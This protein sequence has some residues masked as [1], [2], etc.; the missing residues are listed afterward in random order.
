M[1]DCGH[2]DHLIERRD[3]I[4]SSARVPAQA[5]ARIKGKPFHRPAAK[6]H[7]IKVDV[8]SGEK[9]ITRLDVPKA[10]P[11]PVTRPP[12]PR[13][14]RRKSNYSTRIENQIDAIIRACAQAYD[15]GAGELLSRAKPNWIARPRFAVVRLLR[16]NLR[17]SFPAIGQILNRDHTSV[18]I[19][20]RRCRELR[21]GG[22]DYRHR[23]A[24]AVQIVRGKVAQ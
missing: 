5:R 9:I 19:A 12:L 17:L 8:P 4:L 13:P 3:A 14:P 2:Y 1:D 16:S 10:R 11:A 21:I 20:F 15:V 24:V 6:V 7:H 23:Y 18:L 22:E